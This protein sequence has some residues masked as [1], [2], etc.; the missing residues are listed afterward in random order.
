MTFALWL[1]LCIVVAMGAV[2]FT[3]VMVRWMKSIIRSAGSRENIPQLFKAMQRWGRYKDAGRIWSI[4]LIALVLLTVCLGSYAA[5]TSDRQTVPVSDTAVTE[6]S[7]IAAAV[8]QDSTENVQPQ[9]W[10]GAAANTFGDVVYY[11]LYG[12][13]TVQGI[14]DGDSSN[15]NGMTGLLRWLGWL[16][17]WLIPFLTVGTAVSM[18]FGFLPKPMARKEEYLIFPQL[19][20]NSLLLAEDLMRNDNDEKSGIREDRMVIF[21]RVDVEK[22]TQESKDRLQK[23]RA[24]KYSYTEG[25]LLRIHWRLQRKKLRFFFLSAD[26]ELNF[27]R[28]Q[29]L[30]T[31]VEK[32]RLFFNEQN[33]GGKK[34]FAKKKE[35]ISK[36]E[37]RGEFRQELYLLSESESAPM[38]IDHLRKQ[39][40]KKKD[41][42][43]DYERLPVFAHTEL[44]LLDRYRTV[45]YD[46]MKKKPLYETA[47]QVEDS[48]EM[49]IL[50]L[51]FGRV[52]KA[53]YRTA[54]SFCPMRG[55]QTTFSIWDKDVNTQM[56]LLKLEY[57]ECEKAG[58]PEKKCMDVLS[59]EFVNL[60][61]D[62]EASQKPFT[63]IMLSLGDDERNI[64]VASRLARYYL[65]KYWEST[66]IKL[67]T[68]C[69]NLENS[70][71]TKY[72]SEFFADANYELRLHVFGTDNKTFSEEMLIDRNLWNAAR[73]LHR[74]LKEDDTLSFAYWSEYERRSSVASAAHASWHVESIR[75]KLIE[76]TYDAWFHH[77][78]ATNQD[79]RIKKRLTEEEHKRWVCYS[80][81][82][83]MQEICT[84][85]AR[86]ILD[87]IEHHTDSVAQLTPCLTEAKKLDALY[88]SLYP[89]AEEENR[90]RV[91]A[92]KHPHRRFTERDRFVVSNAELLAQ[93]VS[94]ADREI[95][96]RDFYGEKKRKKPC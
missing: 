78:P 49:R 34:F 68:I 73:K 3:A 95:E 54:A 69:V 85:T 13:Q 19:E 26:T 94:G 28:M 43:K 52:G 15:L 9:S 63:Y 53:F 89:K 81:C 17:S 4:I 92:G 90:E 46:L 33:P 72:V 38:L 35:G 45:M 2:A 83:G 23:I 32:E 25:D 36:E 87:K 84:K 37:D 39:M 91:A 66:D 77:S 56:E 70:I 60:I 20:E 93:I 88:R 27:T 8:T 71:R 22:L 1:V 50:I 51:G 30:L 31:E 5:W 44:R 18:L 80:Q 11:S 7:E 16:V 61:Q 82:E 12:I 55:Y 75:Q 6:P 65:K 76:Q 48:F 57:P 24:R 41:P 14:L 96:L 29:T 21:L 64:K 10:W 40:C 79:K 47:D 86:K 42:K 74:G 58:N 67:P 62:A 59:L